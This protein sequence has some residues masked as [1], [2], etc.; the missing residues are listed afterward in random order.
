MKSKCKDA[1][2]MISK[3]EKRGDYRTVITPFFDQLI[4]YYLQQPDLPD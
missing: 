4:N 1:N 2:N 3:I